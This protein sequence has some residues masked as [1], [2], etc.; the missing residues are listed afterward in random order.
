MPKLIRFLSKRSH[1]PPSSRQNRNKSAQNRIRDLRTNKPANARGSKMNKPK[2]LFNGRYVPPWNFEHRRTQEPFALAERSYHELL[3]VVGTASENAHALRRD[4]DYS[5]MGRQKRIK[6][7]T[8]SNAI[9]VLK[10]GTAQRTALLDRVEKIK[11]DVTNRS[12]DKGDAVGFLRR[13][14]IRRDFHQMAPAKR[15]AMIAMGEISQE[16]ARAIA[17]MPARFSNVSA[18]QHEQILERAALAANPDAAAEIAD[19]GSA[20]DAIDGAMRAVIK[21]LEQD[22]GIKRTDL[23]ELLGE[24]SRA[25]FIRGLLDDE[26]N[27]QEGVDDTQ[28]EPE[29]LEV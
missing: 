20:V 25:D 4:P 24:P 23:R 17:E 15:N 27:P 28:E 26:T 22:A 7:W 14:E 13:Q 6:E 5:D 11:T 19:L 9:P 18:Q 12:V 29:E 2:M 21:T 16:E 8:A 10:A 1:R 3:S